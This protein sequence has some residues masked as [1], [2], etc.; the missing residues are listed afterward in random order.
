V[1][2]ARKLSIAHLSGN[3]A[4]ALAFVEVLRGERPDHQ[5]LR[6]RL[7]SVDL[8]FECGHRRL[9][10]VSVEPGPAVKGL[11]SEGNRAIYAHFEVYRP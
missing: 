4:G 3:A 11:L 5:G 7:A 8:S 10:F 9:D 2:A 1:I 6:W